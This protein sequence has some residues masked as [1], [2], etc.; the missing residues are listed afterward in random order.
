M[1]I[2]VIVI[3]S[4]V[5]FLVV[6]LIAG[7]VIARITM[8]GDDEVVLGVSSG[9]LQPCPDTPNC[10]STFADDKLHRVEPIPTDLSRPEAIAHAGD[11]I[12]SIDRITIVEET[13]GYILARSTS[14]LFGYVDDVEI[15]VPEGT[16]TIHFRSASRA[17]RGDMGVNRRRY[18]EFR[19]HLE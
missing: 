3:V 15:Y 19:S 14:R 17:G 13:D 6:V 12:A 4:I 9:R 1:R 18:E 5:G 2:G 11:A 16:S 8:P 10:V 7:L